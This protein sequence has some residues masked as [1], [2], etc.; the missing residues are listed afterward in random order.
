VNRVPS[1]EPISH[2]RGVVGFFFARNAARLPHVPS[3]NGV[4]P[5]LDRLSLTAAMFPPN[6]LL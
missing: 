6:Q 4:N 3:S 1:Y 5:A 2:S